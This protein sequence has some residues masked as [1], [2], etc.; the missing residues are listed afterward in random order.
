MSRKERGNVS[1]RTHSEQREVQH[2]FAAE[3]PHELGR[4]DVC[5][6]GEVWRIS[7]HPVHRRLGDA[8]GRQ[9]KAIGE[10]EIGLRVGRRNGPL[11]GPEKMDV[12]PRDRQMRQR[13]K[14][15]RRHRSA[16]QRYGKEPTAGD[17][18]GCR[19]AHLVGKTC[20]DRVHV[21]D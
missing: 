1:V 19:H 18:L 6:L 4:V 17:G 2:G 14:G 8:R 3:D 10:T 15:L 5:S 9:P 12:A 21:R 20:H 7:R 16:R 13:R 11:I